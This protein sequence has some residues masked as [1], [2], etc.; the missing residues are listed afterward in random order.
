MKKRTWNCATYANDKIKISIVTKN[1]EIFI[2]CEN[3]N[4]ATTYHT[5]AQAREI[6]S[7]L[8]RL[9]NEIEAQGGAA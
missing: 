2:N 9:A 4:H 6:A 3:G 1:I 7:E 5:P 8:I